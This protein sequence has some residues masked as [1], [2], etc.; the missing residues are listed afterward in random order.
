MLKNKRFE[1]GITIKVAGLDI[2][3]PY[4]RRPNVIR[5]DALFHKYLLAL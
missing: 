4:K 5:S 2:Y 1:K 3:L